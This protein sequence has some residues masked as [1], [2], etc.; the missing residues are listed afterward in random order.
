MT[1]PRITSL[2]L[3]FCP[4]E[5]LPSDIIPKEINFVTIGR[6][7]RREDCTDESCNQKDT[8]KQSVIMVI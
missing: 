3:N 4:N 7:S 6:P 8:N 1:R 5:A 2:D